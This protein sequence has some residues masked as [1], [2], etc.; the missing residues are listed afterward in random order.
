VI[1]RMKDKA[2]GSTAWEEI[3]AKVM[4]VNESMNVE[5]QV[6]CPCKFNQ[7]EGPLVS[8]RA[9]LSM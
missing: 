4:D 1:T 2:V 5:G 6:S 8:I 7:V 3:P 9:Q